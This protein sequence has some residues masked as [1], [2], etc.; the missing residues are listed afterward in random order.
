M[1]QKGTRM[2]KYRIFARNVDKMTKANG[3]TYAG[4]G[5]AARMPLP[6]AE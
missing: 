2:A 3:S 5:W 4:K 1:Q 6:C